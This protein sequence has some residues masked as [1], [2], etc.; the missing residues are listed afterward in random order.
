VALAGTTALASADTAVDGADPHHTAVRAAWAGWLTPRYAR[1]VLTAKIVGPAGLEW[2]TWSRHRAYVVVNAR[3]SG[4]DHPPDTS[5]LAARKVLL[6]ERA[7]GRDGWH[8]EW[9]TVVIVVVLKK[10]NDVW[11]IDSDELS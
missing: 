3:P 8:S 7:V 1:R 2:D 11:R 4:E 6:R 5:E 9:M 10:V